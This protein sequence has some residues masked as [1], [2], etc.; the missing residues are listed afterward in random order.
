MLFLI[1]EGENSFFALKLP[2]LTFQK[3]FLFDF[4]RDRLAS[5]ENLE[6]QSR[7]GVH[8]GAGALG[9]KTFCSGGV[10][11]WPKVSGDGGTAARMNFLL[12]FFPDT[13]WRQCKV[14]Q[15]TIRTNTI[16]DLQL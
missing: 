3:Y 1:K 7:R 16:L 10:K 4:R 11:P 5:S 12:Q 15:F 14:M 13:L 6:A 9:P 2:F 8:P